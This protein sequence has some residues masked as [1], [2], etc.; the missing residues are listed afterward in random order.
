MFGVDYANLKLVLRVFLY[1]SFFSHTFIILIVE[2]FNQALTSSIFEAQIGKSPNIS[3]TN[4]FSD[5][6]QKELALVG[7]LAS[8][9]ALWWRWLVSSFIK[10]FS[11]LSACSINQFWWKWKKKN[12]LVEIWKSISSVQQ[13][14][15]FNSMHSLSALIHEPCHGYILTGWLCWNVRV[16]CSLS[17]TAKTAKN[18]MFKISVVSVILAISFRDMSI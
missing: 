14:L 3:Q 2:T 16:C 7:P 1:C 18:P 9:I 4:N 8:L 15:H 17:K 10:F 6:C 11:W 13:M 5:Y 12:S